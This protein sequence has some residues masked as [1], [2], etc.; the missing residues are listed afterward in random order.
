MDEQDRTKE[1]S[2]FGRFTASI[3][4]FGNKH[5]FYLGRRLTKVH[6]ALYRRSRGRLAGH[7]PGWPGARIV[8]V[9]HIGAKTGRERTS[10]LMYHE[11]GDR[12]V[13]AATKGGQPTNPAW[14]HNLMANPETTIQIGAETREVRARRATEEE[15]ERLWPGFVAFYPGYEFFRTNA[16][17]REIPIVI[18]EPR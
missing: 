5:G 3:S 13:V 18:L 17:D 4:Q 2:L 1:P 16:G 10:P 6:V 14:F 7:L 11:D 8:L 12:V 15:R 9:D